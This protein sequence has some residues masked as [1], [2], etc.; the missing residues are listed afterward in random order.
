MS[1]L[2][3]IIWPVVIVYIV[4]YFFTGHFDILKWTE[5][6]RHTAGICLIILYIIELL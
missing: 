2:Y 3:S 5:D 4:G 6:Q 1:T